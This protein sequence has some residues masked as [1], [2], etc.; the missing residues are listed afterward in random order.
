MH[1]DR[2]KPYRGDPEVRHSGT[3]KNRPPPS[4]EEITNEIETEEEDEDRPFHVIESSTAESQASRNR[5]KVTF[6]LI[7]EIEEQDS[8]SEIETASQDKTDKRQ[9]SPLSTAYEKIPG[10]DSKTSASEH[11]T[12]R[13]DGPERLL[14]EDH[15][16]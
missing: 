15:D 6:R 7:P 9:I 14:D 2:L 1:F 10:D 16:S 5:H 12:V 11:I 8:D 3:L 13:G 4:Y